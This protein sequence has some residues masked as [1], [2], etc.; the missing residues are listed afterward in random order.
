LR[1]LGQFRERGRGQR[2]CKADKQGAEAKRIHEGF[3]L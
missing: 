1:C 2:Q 3:L